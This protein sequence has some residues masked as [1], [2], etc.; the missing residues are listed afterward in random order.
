MKAVED[1]SESLNTLS[2]VISTSF[3]FAK[4]S[5]LKARQSLMDCAGYLQS[6]T[7]K[8]TSFVIRFWLVLLDLL[9]N[10]HVEALVL[11]I[12]SMLQQLITLLKTKEVQAIIAHSLKLAASEPV[13]KLIV[14]ITKCTKSLFFI[15]KTPEIAKFQQQI[16][17]LL[18]DEKLRAEDAMDKQPGMSTSATTA[19]DT[20]AEGY[21]HENEDEYTEDEDFPHD[22]S[23]DEM[24]STRT[25]S[26]EN[27]CVD[28]EKET[29]SPKTS[30]KTT[31]SSLY[32]PYRAWNSIAS[33]TSIFYD[34]ESDDTD[35]DEDNT[36]GNDENNEIEDQFLSP[37]PLSA[38][39]VSSS[40]KDEKT[41][42]N[43]KIPP[44][45]HHRRSQSMKPPTSST[46]PHRRS[47]R[48]LSFDHIA[49]SAADRH[50]A[51][52]ERVP[53]SSAIHPQRQDVVYSDRHSN[54]ESMDNV[55]DVH[56]VHQRKGSHSESKRV[57]IDD[58]VLLI[59]HID[60]LE[61]G[62]DISINE[63]DD[64]R[65]LAMEQKMSLL[66]IYRCYHQKRTRFIRYA[67]NIL[68]DHIQTKSQP[69]RSEHCG[70]ASPSNLSCAESVTTVS[71]MKLPQSMMDEVAISAVS[72]S[73][74]SEKS[75]CN[76]NSGTSVDS[77][78]STM[79]LKT[80]S[81][82]T[83]SVQVEWLT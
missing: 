16:W 31:T 43:L 35:G 80:Q 56:D 47:R 83:V 6:K 53:Y 49:D 40:D 42:D 23:G 45:G 58:W 70:S 55:S 7:F 13:A 75:S 78:I 2:N 81:N 25:N 57:C 46:R 12:L 17:D 26:H 38:F 27:L 71:A 67:R 52:V 82:D 8:S 24:N 48:K 28:D 33:M 44:Q 68:R 30:A 22:G 15:L 9:K 51:S 11:T 76:P 36:P 21:G 34:K 77:V 10:E 64:L 59:Q 50:R 65:K 18:E 69:S 3:S 1:I 74:V 54:L 63:G 66:I 79:D 62:G 4:A 39:H 32:S 29:A 37:S 19:M 61:D 14:G 60:D 73:S 41:A 20:I 72:G 5:P